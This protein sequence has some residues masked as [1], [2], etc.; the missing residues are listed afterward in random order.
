M[1]YSMN[2]TFGNKTNI[3]IAIISHAHAQKH[4]KIKS[5]QRFYV[6]IYK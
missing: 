4:I 3:K 5:N 2:D 1:I 6:Q